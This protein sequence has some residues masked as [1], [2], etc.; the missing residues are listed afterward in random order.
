MSSKQLHSLSHHTFFSHPNFLVL[1]LTGR[2]SQPSSLV[3]EWEKESKRARDVEVK[4]CP[5][6]DNLLALPTNSIFILL[7]KKL[8]LFPPHE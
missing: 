7:N 3:S 8:L 6:I 4:V 1:F 2:E 5:H